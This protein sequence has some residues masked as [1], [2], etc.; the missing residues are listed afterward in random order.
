[1]SMLR[2]PGGSFTRAEKATDW[3]DAINIVQKVTMPRPILLCDREVSVGQFQ[4]S[5]DDPYYPDKEKP[6]DWPGANSVMSPTADHPVQRV[7]WN[8][9]VLFC[10]EAS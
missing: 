6:R 3:R 1:M 8:D 4:Q 7:D 10:G 2:I 9:A 5:A